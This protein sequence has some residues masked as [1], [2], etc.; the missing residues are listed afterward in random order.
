MAQ[1]IKQAYQYESLSTVIEVKLPALTPDL[2]DDDSTFDA[3]HRDVTL[4]LRKF[5]PLRH[6]YLNGDDNCEVFLPR[7]RDLNTFATVAPSAIG[8]AY[9]E[10]VEITSAFACYNLLNARLFMGQ[11]VEINFFNKDYFLTKCL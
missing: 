6:F 3:I 7:K 11:P 5:G 8:K 10:F 4:E 2:L 1:Y 9:A